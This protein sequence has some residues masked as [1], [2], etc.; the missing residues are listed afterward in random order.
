[1]KESV[2][3]QTSVPGNFVTHKQSL[4]PK[5]R[6]DKDDTSNLKISKVNLRKAS[7]TRRTKGNFV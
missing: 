5:P 1:M 7:K 6:I 3:S 2:I 4:N